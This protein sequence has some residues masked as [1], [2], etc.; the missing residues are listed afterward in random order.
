MSLPCRRASFLAVLTGALLTFGSSVVP[1]ATQVP[2]TTPLPL[3][4]FT[5]DMATQAALN[6]VTNVQVWYGRSQ[7]HARTKHSI[8]T[9]DCS[10]LLGISC[11]LL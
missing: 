5:A 6:A 2:G 7:G 3:N 10:L 8:W 11:T 9:L 4:A 1:I